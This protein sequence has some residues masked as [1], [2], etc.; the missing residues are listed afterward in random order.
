VLRILD[1]YPG[2]GFFPIP[3]PGSR[4]PDPGSNH[5]RGGKFLNMFNFL[6]TKNELGAHNLGVYGLLE[7][8]LQNNLFG[9]GAERTRM[10]IYLV[11]LEFS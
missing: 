3:D 7:D 8:D 6:P 5:R 10:Q 11:K 1:V 9:S 4:I 2:S